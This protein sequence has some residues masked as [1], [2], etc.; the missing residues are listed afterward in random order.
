MWGGRVFEIS[1]LSGLGATDRIDLKFL[2]IYPSILPCSAFSVI[3]WPLAEPHMQAPDLSLLRWQA[4]K[5][6]KLF[7]SRTLSREHRSYARILETTKLAA[8]NDN[9]ATSEEFFIFKSAFVGDMY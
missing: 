8:C 9:T 7:A 1:V 3:S 6:S 4:R 2:R 5:V